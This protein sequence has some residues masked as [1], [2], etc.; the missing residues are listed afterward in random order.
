MEE[1]TVHCMVRNEPFVYYAVKSVYDYVGKILL[2]DTGSY[3]E[4][5]LEDIELLLSED[6]DNKIIFEYVPI[7]VDETKWTT[8][9]KSNWKNIASE[10]RNKKGKWYARE[11]MIHD[12]ESK[13][14][15]ILDGDEVYYKEAMETL[16]NVAKDWPKGK[17]CGFVSLIWFFDMEHTF[18]AYSRSGRIFLTNEIGMTHTSP[19]EVHTHKA[20]GQRIRKNSGYSFCIPIKPYAHFETFLKP[21]RRQIEPSKLQK[22]TDELPEV[23]RENP[24]FIERFLNERSN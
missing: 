6:V 1:L 8:G 7:E 16:Q 22:F 3:D 15:I 9:E 24:F 4:H 20:S 10:G 19:G 13:F 17:I 2:Y 23:M 14:F 5:T 21:W 11:K 12:T 18:P